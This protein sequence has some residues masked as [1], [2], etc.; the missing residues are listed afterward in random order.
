M[1]R[2]RR[3]A[4]RRRRS[5]S[6]RPGRRRLDL[7][8]VSGVVLV[9]PAPSREQHPTLE[10][11]EMVEEEN[12]VQMVDLV[13]DGAGLETGRFLPVAGPILIE[14]LD[15]DALRTGD[16]SVD[17]RNREAALLSR[18]ATLG[19]DDGRVDH[20]EPVAVGVYHGHPAGD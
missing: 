3:P 20:D 19:L 15:D 17:L 4:S 11:A 8:G 13:L 2:R 18:R 12:A 10:Q 1:T 5:S 6:L 9:L 7:F 14:R 16:V